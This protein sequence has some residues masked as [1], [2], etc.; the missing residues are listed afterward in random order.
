MTE[1]G[2][3]KKIL[4]KIAKL[5]GTRDEYCMKMDSCSFRPR[6]LKKASSDICLCKCDDDDELAR[7]G[8]Y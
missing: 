3:K 1:E 7:C 4:N 5:T 8:M 2:K 6:S